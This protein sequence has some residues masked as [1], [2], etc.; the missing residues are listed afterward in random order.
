[1]PKV[2]D[3]IAPFADMPPVFATASMVAHIEATCIACVHGHLDD[4]EHTVGTH[5]DLSHSAATPMGMGVT[6]SVW[7]TPVD[8]RTLTFCVEVHDEAGPIGAGT[9]RRAV[10]DIAPFMAKVDQ[11]AAGD[12][13]D[14]VQIADAP[15]ATPE[16]R[17]RVMPTA[18]RNPG[19]ETCEDNVTH[20]RGMLFDTVRLEPIARPS[21]RR[22][23]T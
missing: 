23:G 14:R 21:A 5:V 11:K 13:C 12:S 10:I 3:T 19:D 1:M 2:S 20:R 18:L 15:G 7:L 4:G 6:A 16:D 8:G 22:G 9:H 17:H